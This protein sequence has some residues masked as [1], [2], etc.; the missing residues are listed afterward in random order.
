MIIEVPYPEGEVGEE[1]PP[2][3][4]RLVVVLARLPANKETIRFDNILYS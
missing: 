4:S 3:A 1:G 2:D